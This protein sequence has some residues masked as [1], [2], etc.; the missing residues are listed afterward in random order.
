MMTTKKKKEK[1][2]NLRK[3]LVRI[4]EMKRKRKKQIRMSE[5]QINKTEFDG[6]NISLY[7]I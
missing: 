5:W 3:Y 1:K 6:I 2:K 4:N 7:K